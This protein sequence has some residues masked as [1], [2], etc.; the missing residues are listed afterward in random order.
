[1]S[2]LEL[3]RHCPGLIFSRCTL[4][5]CRG[6]KS[7]YHCSID[8]SRWWP[9]GPLYSKLVL[10]SSPWNRRDPNILPPHLNLLRVWVF[11]DANEA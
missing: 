5:P 4:C 1:M 3:P 8:T 9:T 7:I 6:T 10:S 11:N 2:R